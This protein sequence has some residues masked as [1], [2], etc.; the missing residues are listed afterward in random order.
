MALAV[1]SGHPPVPG[2]IC[3]APHT[4]S[5]PMPL[6]NVIVTLVVAGVLLWLVNTYLPMDGKVKKILNVV[7]VVVIVI[8]LL[9]AFGILGSLG[10]IGIR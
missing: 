10:T 6:I 4:E 3:H 9:Q 5:D 7:V 8:W 1:A 2:L